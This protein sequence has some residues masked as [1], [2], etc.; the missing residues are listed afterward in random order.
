MNILVV[1]DDLE[2]QEI[3]GLKIEACGYKYHWAQN[4][5][6]GLALLEKFEFSLIIADVKMPVMDGMTFLKALRKTNRSKEI[7]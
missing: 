5:Q 1:E 7:L 4:G 3:Y 2:I 6:E